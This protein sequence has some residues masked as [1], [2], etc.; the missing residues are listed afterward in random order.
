MWQ[1]A[2]DWECIEYSLSNSCNFS[3]GSKFFKIEVGGVYIKSS[4]TTKDLQ[5][6]MEASLFQAITIHL[7]R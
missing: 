7:E 4:S 6:L 3:V 1:N 2:Y 5:A